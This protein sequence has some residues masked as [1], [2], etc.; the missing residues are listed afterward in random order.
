MIV[1]QRVASAA[2]VALALSDRE[3]QPLVSAHFT[4]ASSDRGT[5]RRVARGRD[6]PE[7][8]HGGGQVHHFVLKKRH[9]QVTLELLHRNPHADRP[10]PDRIRQSLLGE[11]TLPQPVG[12]GAA[13]FV[14]R[15]CD[16]RN[17]GNQEAD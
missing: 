4:P 16:L 6:D 14:Q 12:W 11:V 1:M 9:D 2:K 3:C 7:D 10:K 17:S 5:M 13:F 8:R 15:D